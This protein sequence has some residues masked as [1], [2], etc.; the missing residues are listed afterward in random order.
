MKS[1]ILKLDLKKAYDCVNWYFIRLILLQTIFGLLLT[2]WIMCCVTTVTY[3]VLINGDPT[4]Y[5]QSGHGLKKG[6][7]LFPLLFILV[8][9]GLYR[10]LQSAQTNGDITSVKISR[11]Q[12]IINLFLVDD[13]LIMPKSILSEW[14]AIN[15]L[16]SNFFRDFV[17]CINPLESTFHFSSLLEDDL[18]TL[19]S[20]FPYKFVNLSKGFRYLGFFLKPT[21]YRVEYWCWLIHKYEKNIGLWCH[22]WLSLGGQ[23]ILV[24]SMLE[25]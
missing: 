5:F 21:Y 6:C 18:S 8:M 4:P 14:K 9:E 20:L 23:Y 10:L 17:L 19:S 11:S 16:L 22:R 15:S 12:K 7:S 13:V 25:S 2:D 3:S 1:L 24:K